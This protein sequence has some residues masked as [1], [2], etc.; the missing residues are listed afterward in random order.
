MEEGD[1]FKMDNKIIKEY[2]EKHLI[3]EIG[4]KNSYDGEKLVVKLLIDEEEIS[5]DYIY[6]SDLVE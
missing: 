6:L 1:E 4:N 3:I 5:S 2:L